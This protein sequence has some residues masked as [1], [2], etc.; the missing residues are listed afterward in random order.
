MISTFR[1]YIATVD[2]NITT[3]T[4]RKPLI[5]GSGRK[6]S[7]SIYSSCCGCIAAADSSTVIGALSSYVAAINRNISAITSITTADSSSTAISHNLISCI[8]ITTID[9]N[10]SATL[11]SS[12]AKC[13]CCISVRI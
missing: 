6:N 13:S 10:V 1:Y 4:A 11:T 8:D 2:S 12:T 9:Y 3:Q 7:V 5:Y